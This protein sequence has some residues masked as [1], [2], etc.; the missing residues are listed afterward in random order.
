MPRHGEK[1][2]GICDVHSLVNNDNAMREVYY[3]EDC[4]AWMCK[5]CEGDIPKRAL[6]MVKRPIKKMFA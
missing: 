4:D 1:K 5:R 3:C 6:A 2:M